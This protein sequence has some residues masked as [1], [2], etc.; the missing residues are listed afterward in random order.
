MTMHRKKQ[1]TQLMI[2][3]QVEQYHLQRAAGN[4]ITLCHNQKSTTT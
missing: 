3:E 2:G 1:I 4:N